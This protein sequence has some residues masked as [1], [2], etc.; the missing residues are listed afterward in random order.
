[1]WEND[2]GP[3]PET[4]RGSETRWIVYTRKQELRALSSRE[5]RQW[6]AHRLPQLSQNEKRARYKMV[7][8][9]GIIQT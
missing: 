9:L 6:Q 2:L 4:D 1:M 7:C 3:N 5:S 8:L